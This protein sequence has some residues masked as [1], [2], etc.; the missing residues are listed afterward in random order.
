MDV[1][2]KS[3]GEVWCLEGIVNTVKNE[4]QNDFGSISDER[5]DF[6]AAIAKELSCG[7]P[8]KYWTRTKRA[9]YE[10]RV[11]LLCNTG[12]KEVRPGCPVLWSF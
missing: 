10:A 7:I 4:N 11:R 3:H 6:Q 8:K 2:N 9:G 1:S 5:K 12:G